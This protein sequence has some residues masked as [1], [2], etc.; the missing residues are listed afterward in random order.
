MS[1]FPGGA[2]GALARLSLRRS[3]QRR[4]LSRAK[5]H[6]TTTDERRRRKT[7]TDD[8]DDEEYVCFAGTD[9]GARLAMPA[10]EGFDPSI[11]TFPTQRVCVLISFDSQASIAHTVA[12]HSR[13]RHQAAA[14]A[15][16]TAEGTST[17]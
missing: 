17:F 11:G 9:A 1:T 14:S 7:T 4:P 10:L 13:V 6:A 12:P 5:R 2:R 8:E 15:A 16:R 3:P